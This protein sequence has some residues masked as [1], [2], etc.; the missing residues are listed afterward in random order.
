MKKNAVKGLCIFSSN[1]LHSS[2]APVATTAL[3]HHRPQSR[4]IW[5][6]KKSL[7]SNESQT[8]IETPD[9][10][11]EPRTAKPKIVHSQPYDPSKPRTEPV[12]SISMSTPVPGIKPSNYQPNFK[13]P[14][15][16]ITK[17]PSGLTVVSIENYSETSAV[18]VFINAGSRHETPVTNGV[19]HL[20][21]R[22][23][24]KA[25]MNR[26]T[27]AIV[28]ELENLG[29]NAQSSSDR[30]VIN[31][32][33][34]GLREFVPVALDVLSD[35]VQNSLILPEDI[36]EQKVAIVNEYDDNRRDPTVELTELFH[37][38][39]YGKESGLGL[40]QTAPIDNLHN[41]TYDH[42]KSFV[43]QFFVP[44]R[45][46]V[47]VAGYQ[48]ED[49]L[50]LVNNTFEKHFMKE[51]DPLKKVG[52]NN[53][54]E[55]KLFVENIKKNYVGGLEVIDMTEE[56]IDY[57]VGFQPGNKEPG[58][59]VIFGFETG[60][61]NAEDLY[62]LSVLKSMLGGGMSF[63]SGGPG[64]GI[65]T[66]LYRDVLCKYGW[67]EAV[68]C[69]DTRFDDTG[70]FGLHGVSDHSKIYDTFSK[71]LDELVKT[72]T[73]PI[74]QEELS[75]AKNQ[76]KNMVCTN[77]ESRTMVLD[78]VGRQVLS[79]G[80]R[81]GLQEMCNQI[82]AVTEEQIQRFAL[83]MLKTKPTLVVKT[84]LASNNVS[85]ERKYQELTKAL[86][87]L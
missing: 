57:L 71:M 22:M 36:E 63:S 83:K 84:P 70:V 81:H 41:I 23:G 16:F 54:I 19:T 53:E 86:S 67:I 65:F 47:A 2:L 82:D 18:G 27:A 21:Q 68:M 17:L 31:H 10:A 60:S 46:V 75:R 76:L 85:W 30:D 74:G 8:V 49:F 62:P 59:H 29:A 55:S 20:L 13:D 48:H 80:K 39:A 45:M 12:L 69:F 32:I 52:G 7:E 9:E 73:K 61:A 44:E 4:N 11:V 43:E 64:K 25:T 77:L 42:L 3:H 79:S 5:G 1:V 78:D 72:V 34:E 24:Y 26:T 15:T 51:R 58:S 66:R 33:L 38:V 50:E 56:E 87:R 6:K 35:C 14:D 37:R 28:S 40:S